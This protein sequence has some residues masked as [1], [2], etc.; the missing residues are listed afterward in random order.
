MTKS[1]QPVVLVVGCGAIGGLY[2]A[3]LAKVARVSTLDANPLQ[4]E[5]IRRDGLTVSGRTDAFAR[6]DATTDPAQFSKQACDAVIFAVK[7]MHTRD[8]AASLLP[9]LAG[10]PLLLTLQNG[11]GNV[12]LLSGLCDLDILQGVTWEAGEIEAP[13][14]IR[15]LIHGPSAHIG[16]ARCAGTPGAWL[17]ALLSRAGL[18]TS[19]EPEPLG[20]IWSKF[21]F[22]CAMN[23][24]SAL[25]QGIPEAKYACEDTYQMLAATIAEGKQVAACEG[26]LLAGDPMELIEDVRAGRRP[27][28]SHPGSMAMDMA[29]GIPTEIEDL[30]G[31]MLKKARRHG[32]A[33]PNHEML[34]R[35]I[36]GLEFGLAAQRAR[37][38]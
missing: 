6:I 24:I 21:I 7:S 3:H 10:R 18:P 17:A 31:Y 12:E 25:L 22:N 16:P 33:A 14:R 28:P 8:A 4:V 34:Y 5:A 29:R 30:T 26:I 32:V 37:T 38:P 35:L 27:R 19:F 20:H 2:A 36:K 23:P 11:Q 15:H 1:D 9:H 13:G